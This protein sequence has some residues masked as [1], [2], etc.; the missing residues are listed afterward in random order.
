MKILFNFCLRLVLALFIIGSLAS[1]RANNITVSSLVLTNINTGT[2]T[3]DAQFNVSWENSWFLNP[4]NPPGNY[5]A[6]W[7]IIKY[8][9]GDNIWR[10]AT[11][12]GSAAN[13]TIPAAFPI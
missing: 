7:L 11:L 10:T 9:I 13:Y 12:D 4:A 2:R 1:A 5:D 8:H 3:L 6:A